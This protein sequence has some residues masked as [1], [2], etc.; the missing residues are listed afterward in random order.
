MYPEQRR[1]EEGKTRN[2]SMPS[3]L[4]TE[5]Q[6]P[7]LMPK[8]HPIVLQTE[9]QYKAEC[10]AKGVK[11]VEPTVVET[12]SERY[13]RRVKMKHAMDPTLRDKKAKYMKDWHQQKKEGG[14]Q[15][16]DK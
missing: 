7:S 12:K 16:G 5:F 2:G 9:L 8:L 6:D 3:S 15:C 4:V 10:E 11:Y 13:Y 1:N 14:R